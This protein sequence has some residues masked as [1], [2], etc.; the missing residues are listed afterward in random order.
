LQQIEQLSRAEL[1]TL[2]RQKLQRVVEYAYQHAPYYRKLFERVGFHPRELRDDF[3][4]LQ[5]I[6]VLTKEIIRENFDDLLTT[7]PARRR[8]LS[9]VTTSGSTGSPLVFMQDKDYRD[10]VTADI[11]R[12]LAWGGWQLGQP[13]AYIWGA[14][15]EVAAQESARTR[16]ID[17]VWNRFT[18]NAFVLTEGSMETFAQQ[19]LKQ[20][21]QLLF[22]YASSLHRFAQ[23]VRQHPGYQRISFKGV[24]SSAEVLLPAARQFIEETFQCKVFNRYGSKELGGIACE[25]EAHTGLHISMENN[26]VEILDNGK[27]AET[28]QTGDIIVTNLNNLGM[29]FIRYSTGDA[30]VWRVDK[31]CACGRAA[32]MLQSVEGR[33]VDAFLTR[34]GRTAWAGFAGAG[35][36]GLAHPA[37]KQFQ[38]TQKSLDLMLVRLAVRGEVPQSVLDELVKT[39]K[40]AFGENVEVRFEFCDQIP[41]LSSGKHQYAVS[42]IN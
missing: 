25:C 12:H 36:S 13:H 1:E 6:P 27:A 20:R 35:Y 40:T 8:Q 9:K 28:G 5:K 42:E 37:I 16:L 10:A 7:E 14:N 3:E 11:Q 41:V 2:Q 24:F 15:F 4:A 30:G 23:F 18:T 22:G 34:D 32:P 31:P 21:P 19:V 38:V 39:F 17:W 26:F 33:L 29:P